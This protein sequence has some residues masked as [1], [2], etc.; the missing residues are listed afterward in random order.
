MMIY[1]I[2]DGFKKGNFM[3]PCLCKFPKVGLWSGSFVYNPKFMKLCLD[4]IVLVTLMIFYID[5]WWI[6]DVWMNSLVVSEMVGTWVLLIMALKDGKLTY[7]MKNVELVGNWVMLVMAL[8]NGKM[9]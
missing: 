4:W 6:V 8:E 2:I 5:L 3:N 7:F 1:V 9:A